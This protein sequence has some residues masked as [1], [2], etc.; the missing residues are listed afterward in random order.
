MDIWKKNQLFNLFDENKLEEF[1]K[2]MDQYFN[3]SLTTLDQHLDH[4]HS[5]YFFDIDTTETEQEII[6]QAQLPV[7]E[8]DRVKLEMVN[9]QLRVLIQRFESEQVQND[10]G[11]TLR[12]ENFSKRIERYIPLPPNTS[13][14]K[15][16]ASMSGDQL[17]IRIPKQ[18][19]HSTVIDIDLSD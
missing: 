4:F 3:D 12:S 8:N 16:K 2:S 13:S 9:Q 5:T 15:V 1:M 14:E 7:R 18:A 6:L 10:Q 11:Q 19:D 17:T